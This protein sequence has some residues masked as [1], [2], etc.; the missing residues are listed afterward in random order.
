MDFPQ[1]THGQSPVSLGGYEWPWSCRWFQITL[2]SSWRGVEHSIPML[3]WCN[4]GGMGLACRKTILTYI[5]H[6][7]EARLST[8]GME[9]TTGSGE[10]GELWRGVLT[11][12][13]NISSVFITYL[14]VNELPEIYEI[15]AF[16]LSSI[17]V[18]TFIHPIRTLMS[19]IHLMHL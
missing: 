15:N 2:E 16:I 12:I 1:P 18:L 5:N 11:K 3:H 19:H 4:T 6:W 8:Y 17:Q 7:N 14:T 9:M 10:G 13:A